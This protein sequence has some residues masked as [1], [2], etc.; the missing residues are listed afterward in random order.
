[1]AGQALRDQGHEVTEDD[2]RRFV[3]QMR[4]RTWIFGMAGLAANL[5]VLT[6]N[7]V[8]GSLWWLIPVNMVA[9]AMTAYGMRELIESSRENRP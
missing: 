4:R 3:E 1:V 8:W 7:L 2:A 9:L 6:Y 5:M